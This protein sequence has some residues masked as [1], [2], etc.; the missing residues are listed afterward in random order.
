MT[1]FAVVINLDAAKRLNLF[2]P[3]DLLNIAETVN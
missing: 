2:P 3:I 1:D